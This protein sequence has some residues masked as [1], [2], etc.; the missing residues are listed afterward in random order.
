MSG[1]GQYL[2]RFAY[3]LIFFSNDVQTTTIAMAITGSLCCSIL[4]AIIHVV[5]LIHDPPGHGDPKSATTPTELAPLHGL[6]Q[7]TQRS[8]MSTSLDVLCIRCGRL[9]SNQKCRY[10]MCSGCCLGRRQCRVHQSL[11]VSDSVVMGLRITGPKGID[12]SNSCMSSVPERL[13]FVGAQL[14]YLNLSCNSLTQLPPDIGCLQGLRE[15]QLNGNQLT[16]I[17]ST[18]GSLHQLTELNLRHNQLA[19]IPDALLHVTCMLS[20]ALLHVT[21]MLSDALLHVLPVCCQMPAT[22]YLYV[23]RCSATCYL[24]VVRC[25]ATFYLY[26]VRCSATCVTCMLSDALLHV[27]CMLSDALLHVTCLLSDALLHVLPVCCQMLC[28]MCYLYVVRCSATCYL[29]VVR[30]SATCYLYVVRCS[31]T[32]YLYVVR[33]SAACVTCMLSDALIHVLPVCCQMLC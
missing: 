5:T 30:C 16:H 20:D 33:C 8:L 27:T 4:W 6:T 21:C 18:L 13:G 24:F 25:S 15:L 2:A 29:Y 32:C 26:V 19:D 31:A 12:L 14:T 23:V 10:G 11:V 17:P 9:M 7:M 22:C 3:D 1:W 28:Y